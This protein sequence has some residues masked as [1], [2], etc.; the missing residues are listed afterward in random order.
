M[1][2][3]LTLMGIVFFIIYLV[4]YA[5]SNE[6]NPEDI[7]YRPRAVKNA[8]LIVVPIVL[9]LMMVVGITSF[10]SYCALKKKNVTVQQYKVALNLYVT[11]ANIPTGATGKI[12]SDLTDQKY[13][14]YQLKLSEYVRHYRD[15][16][17]SYNRL[18]VSKTI[19]NNSWYFG[20]LVIG[21]DPDM[22]L[23]DLQGEII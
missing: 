10:N 23:I 15:A 1:G 22:A 12:I 7:V 18:L 13:E 3:I 2:F 21:P 8:T 5:Y 11:N 4:Y 6:E 19:W 14:G 9:T 17:T 16:V 20:W